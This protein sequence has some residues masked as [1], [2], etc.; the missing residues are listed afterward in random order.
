MLRRHENKILHAAAT[1]CGACRPLD[2][3]V[4]GELAADGEVVAE[5]AAQGSGVGAGTS[6]IQL[7]E[8]GA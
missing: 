8:A 1:F 4:E 3:L 6:T 7:S 5:G 2:Y